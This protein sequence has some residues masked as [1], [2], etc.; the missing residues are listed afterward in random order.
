MSDG[1]IRRGLRAQES[2]VDLI[3]SSVISVFARAKTLKLEVGEDGWQVLSRGP[4][5][6]GVRHLLSGRTCQRELASA[7]CDS[8]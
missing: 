1:G 8:I 3:L 7:L 6:K 4:F 5:Q 2:S